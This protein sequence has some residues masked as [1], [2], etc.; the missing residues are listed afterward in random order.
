[1]NDAAHMDRALQLAAL[2]R[3]STAPNPR[4]GCVIVR[5]GHVVGEGWHR[6]TGEPHAEV[7]A[8]RAA[9]PQARGAT[10]YVTLEPCSHYGRTPPCADALIAAG[11]GRVVVAMQDPNPLVAGRGLQA[12][13]EAGI[14]VSLGEG[15]AA[16]QALNRGFIARLTRSRPWLTLKLAASLDGRTAMA[17][18]ESRWITGAA[19]RADVHRLRAEAGAV[20]VGADTVCHDDP[21]L[22]VRDWQPA[23]PAELRAPDR[24]VL[25]T[26]ARVPRDAR[27]WRD[28]GARR[29]WALAAERAAVTSAPPGVQ[30][31]A[32]PLAPA[33]AVADGLEADGL[34]DGAG[35]GRHLHL[36]ALL[37]A[38]A[39]E[40]V[41]E[42]LAEAGP[43]LA[44]AL[45]QAGVVDELLLYLAPCLL[46]DAA[47]PLAVLPGL[48]AL[49]ERLALRY[50]AADT[51]GDDLRLRL[52]PH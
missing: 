32:L 5:D 11:V 52:R 41:N 29:Y 43:H 38:L 22:D 39:A 19:A 10:V 33:A 45:L 7:H 48:Q 28:D 26:R 15:A 18:G 3:S 25:D 44:G 14:A 27:V 47:R 42:V 6:R 9:G 36:P 13:R 21:A 1:M 12:L 35:A 2:G 20:L 34:E 23:P 17:S 40:G 30:V 51:V 4:V 31:L 8:L 37:Q 24:I 16:A 46:G 50:C 49:A